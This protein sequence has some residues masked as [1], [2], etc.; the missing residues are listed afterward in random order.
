MVDER[1]SDQARAIYLDMIGGIAGDMFVAAL[2]D[3]DPELEQRC[4]ETIHQIAE[5]PPDVRAEFHNYKSDSSFGKQFTVHRSAPSHDGHQSSHVGFVDAMRIVRRSNISGTVCDRAGDIFEHLA[6]CEG[7]VHAVSMDAVVFHEV[8]GWDSIIDI[9]LAAF[10][11]DAFADHNWTCG[12]IPAGR[13]TVECAHGVLPVPTPA[14]AELLRGFTIYQDKHDGERVTPTGAAILRHL[15]P[16]QLQGMPTSRLL[17]FGSGY[18][19]KT[20]TGLSNVLRCYVLSIELSRSDDT[21]A[22]I[23]FDIDDQSPEDLAI[24]IEAIRA[25]DGVLD[26]VQTPYVGKKGRIGSAVRVLAAWESIGTATDAC[27]S[28]TSTIG[29]RWHRANRRVLDR[30]FST[31]TVGRRTAGVKRVQRPDGELTVKVESDDLAA[32]GN[33]F[34][35]RERIRSAAA[36]ANADSKSPESIKDE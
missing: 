15:Q 26:V 5:L 21:V 7:K 30:E 25:S 1:A 17:A 10:V 14:T 2:C 29:V 4:K 34:G 22:V 19:S 3:L 24:G 13:G 9:I 28:A 11:I 18:G 33:S 35:E 31:T 8:G 6:R 32:A 36:S 16:E 12:P 20:F 27:L 23:E